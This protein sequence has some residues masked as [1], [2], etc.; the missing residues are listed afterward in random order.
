MLILG[1]DFETTG[2]NI[3]TIGVTEIGMVF[4]D[5]NL[6]A[7]IKLFGAV[8][9]PGTQAVWEPGVEKINNLTPTIC[10]NYGMPDDKALKYVLS[11]YGSCDVACAHNGNSFDRPVLDAWAARYG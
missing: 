7:P 10:S 3:P 1:L 6:R 4:W 5:T 8:V 9:D 11:W 2:L